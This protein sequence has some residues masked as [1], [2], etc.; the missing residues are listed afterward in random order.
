MSLRVSRPGT[1][2]YHRSYFVHRNLAKVGFSISISINASWPHPFSVIPQSLK[3]A[4]GL[5]HSSVIRTNTLF[6]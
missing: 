3:F 4:M 5:V 1:Q 2:G 6:L